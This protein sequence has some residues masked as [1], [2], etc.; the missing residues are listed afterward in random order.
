MMTVDKSATGAP[1]F[2]LDANDP[3]A[4]ALVRLWADRHEAATKPEKVWEENAERDNIGRVA[5]SGKWVTPPN[6]QQQCIDNARY[7]AA[8]MEVYKYERDNIYKVARSDFEE[9]TAS[10][11]AEISQNPAYQIYDD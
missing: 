7:V 3:L 2:T 6:P 5:S 11:Q 9:M 8:C 10:Q 4:P 1:I